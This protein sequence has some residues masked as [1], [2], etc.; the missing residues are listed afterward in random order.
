MRKKLDKISKQD[1]TEIEN[2]EG[3]ERFPVDCKVSLP[4]RWRCAYCNCANLGTA[5]KCCNCK[6]DKKV[7][8]PFRLHF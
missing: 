4:D 3:V 6:K 7:G 2:M 8:S 1:N 5:K